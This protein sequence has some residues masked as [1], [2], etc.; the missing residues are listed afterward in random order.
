MVAHPL[1]V[2][3]L[4]AAQVLAAVPVRVAQVLAAEAV[5][6]VAGPPGVSRSMV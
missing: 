3:V 1:Q 4:E 6:G 2:R 5:Q